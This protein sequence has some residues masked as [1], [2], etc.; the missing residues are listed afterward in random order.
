MKYLSFSTRT[1]SASKSALLD[2][3]SL[4]SSRCKKDKANTSLLTFCNTN[5]ADTRIQIWSILSLSHMQNQNIFNVTFPP[6]L[7]F[8]LQTS[9]TP[10]SSPACLSAMCSSRVNKFFHC[11]NIFSRGILNI[12]EKWF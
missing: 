3:M 11:K 10:F 4:L 6:P 8:P 2:K 7:F 9:P 12:I 1:P 5:S